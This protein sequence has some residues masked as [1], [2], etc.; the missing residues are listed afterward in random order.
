MRYFIRLQYLGTHFFGWQKQTEGRT[1]QGEIQAACEKV[2]K[3]PI[4]IVGC[5]R[6]D[7]GVHASFYV[8]HFEVIDEIADLN[9]FIYKINRILGPEIAIDAIKPVAITLHARYQAYRREYKYHLALEKNPF[10]QEQAYHYPYHLKPDLEILNKAAME[11]A[12]ATNF[13][14]FSKTGSQ[15]KS[16]ECQIYECYW[17]QSPDG[18]IFT[19]AANR[20]LR[21]M[22]RLLVGACINVAI[23]KLSLEDLRHGLSSGQRP[24]P[25]WSVPGH[26][27]FLTDIRYPDFEI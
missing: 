22:V 27:L 11:I 4:E 7:A 12:K 9:Q 1:V 5:G 6:T 20:F 17:D 25:N 26:G 2:L 24:H 13:K 10:N 16:F 14:A 21:G 15:V 3:C 19:I 18:Y 23:D 8:A